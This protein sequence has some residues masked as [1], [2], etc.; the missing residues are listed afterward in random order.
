MSKHIRWDREPEPEQ[1]AP[2]RPQRKT[3]NSSLRSVG[4][5][6]ER[7]AWAQERFYASLPSLREQS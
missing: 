4:R 3:R 1:P 6:A 2:P 5:G 7:R